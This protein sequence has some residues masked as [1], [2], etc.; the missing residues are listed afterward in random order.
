M[1]RK[2]EERRRGNSDCSRGDPAVSKDPNEWNRSS[3][4]ISN[5]WVCGSEIVLLLRV[6]VVQ[7]HEREEHSGLNVKTGK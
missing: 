7:H 4:E 6:I 5:Q 3:C 2:G 1:E